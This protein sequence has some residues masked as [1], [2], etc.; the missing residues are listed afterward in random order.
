M[1]PITTSENRVAFLYRFGITTIFQTNILFET[2]IFIKIFIP[3]S[4]GAGPE[5]IASVASPLNPALIA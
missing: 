4:F 5:A 3:V 1:I 2:N